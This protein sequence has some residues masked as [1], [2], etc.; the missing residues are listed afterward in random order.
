M[1]QVGLEAGNES[2][3][4]LGGHNALVRAAVHFLAQARLPRPIPTF[5][6]STHA[7]KNRTHLRILF[8]YARHDG[9]R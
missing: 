9:E 2:Y 5:T 6:V 3:R 1:R 8:A 7:K 4:A